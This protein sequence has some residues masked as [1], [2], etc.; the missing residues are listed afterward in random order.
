MFWTLLALL[1]WVVLGGFISYYGDL[2][3]RRWGKKRISKFGLRPKHTAILITSVTGGVIALLSVLTLF[4]I[5]PPVRDVLLRGESA[6]SENKKLNEKYKQDRELAALQLRD[7]VKRLGVFEGQ[8]R[9]TQ[10]QLGSLTKQTGELR[11]QNAVLMARKAEL[12]ERAVML[13]E[14]VRDQGA[15]VRTA[16]AKITTLNGLAAELTVWNQNAASINSDLAKVNLAMFRENEALK[17][18]NTDLQDDIAKLQKTKTDLVEQIQTKQASYDGVNEAYHKLLDANTDASRSLD[19]EIAT[20][21]RERDDIARARELLVTELAGNSHD[22]AQTYLALRSS[23]LTLRAG[24]ELARLT[25]DSHQGAES[26][27]AALNTLLDRAASKAAGYGAAR[28]ENGREVAIVT[29]RVVNSGRTQNDDEAASL[30]NFTRTLADSDTPTTV[31]AYV[32]YN[33]LAGETALVDLNLQKIVPV[34]VTGDTVA[35]RRLNAKQATDE[36][37]SEVLGFLQKEVRDAAIQKGIVPQVDPRTGTPEVGVAQ[38][39]DLF[40]VT[41]QARRMGGTVK[42]SAIVRRNLTSADPLDVELRAERIARPIV[43]E[44]QGASLRSRN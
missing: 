14:K 41:E 20:L 34:Y 13:E 39:S 9:E 22:F 43:S 23:K 2:Q 7:D 15:R 16:Q 24:G 5:V 21:K 11:G 40:R 36:V 3:G 1:L 8:L 35:T 25:I 18:T 26:V 19:A 38:Y 4:L 17:H 42:I 6:I 30:A 37:F 31:I 28:G 10:A 44:V 29:K 32:V 12:Q 27:R 33:S